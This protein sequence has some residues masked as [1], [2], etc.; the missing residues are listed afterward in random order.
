M[1]N[2]TL[3]DLPRGFLNSAFFQVSYI[4]FHYRNTQY[5]VLKVQETPIPTLAEGIMLDF[6][7][8]F[9]TVPNRS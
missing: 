1:Y 4:L 9:Q 6:T 7:E 8:K 3:V 2:P 5:L